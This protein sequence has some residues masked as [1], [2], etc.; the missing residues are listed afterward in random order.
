M[1]R[2]EFISPI[3]SV[4]ALPCTAGARQGMPVDGSLAARSADAPE[5]E[6]AS[7][8]HCNVCSRVARWLMA[9]AGLGP[10]PVLLCPPAVGPAVTRPSSADAVGQFYKGKQITFVVGTAV[11]G[12]YD[13][14]AR[15]TARHLGK[16]IPG[17]PRFVV[18][19]IPTA[20]S[21][22]AANNLYNTFPKDGTYIGLLIRNI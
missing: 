18:Q 4:A 19:N 3:G 8:S 12:G 5:A 17:N 14:L 16:H 2:R 20:N 13:M 6:T 21:M 15:L 1:R 9:E 7:K 11:G 10:V 22:V